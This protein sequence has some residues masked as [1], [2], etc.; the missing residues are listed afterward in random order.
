MAF[1][2]YNVEI[3][4]KVGMVGGLEELAVAE[5]ADA[6]GGQGQAVQAA[7]VGRVTRGK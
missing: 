2:A 1:A 5:D 7:A 6:V 3:F 4:G